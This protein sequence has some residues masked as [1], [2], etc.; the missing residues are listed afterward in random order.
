[1]PCVPVVP[2]RAAVVAQ[3]DDRRARSLAGTR[4]DGQFRHTAVARYVL[5]VQ[6][7]AD[8]PGGARTHTRRGR[9]EPAARGAVFR[10]RP[11]A[12]L[13]RAQARRHLPVCAS[14]VPPFYLS[15][16]YLVPLRLLRSVSLSI[17]S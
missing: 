9:R 17:H 4:E 12:R 5:A 10:R 13:G 15:F 8:Q 3:R 1:R 11:R 2:A 6:L 7:P 16:Y 14:V